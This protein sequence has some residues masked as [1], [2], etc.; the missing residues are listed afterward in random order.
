MKWQY[1]VWPASIEGEIEAPNEDEARAATTE[2]AL[3]QATDAILT[4]T[5]EMRQVDDG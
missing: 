4:G 2:D 1:E 3:R 5:W